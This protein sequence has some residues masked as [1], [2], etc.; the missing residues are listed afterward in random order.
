MD[1]DLFVFC[2]VRFDVMWYVMA[3]SFVVVV[4]DVQSCFSSWESFDDRW[5]FD[6]G[7][8]QCR[9]CLEHQCKILRHC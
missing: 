6:F 3:V 7:K 4:V 5:I 2:S 8:A 9:S 1:L